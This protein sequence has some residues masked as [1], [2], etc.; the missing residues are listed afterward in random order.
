MVPSQSPVRRQGAGKVA[1]GNWEGQ[2]EAEDR[3]DPGLESH[4][5]TVFRA[6]LGHTILPSY[7]E[8]PQ[9]AWWLHSQDP[10]FPLT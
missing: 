6:G 3:A 8:A 4:L 7:G 5:L 9:G 2:P 1:V 10:L